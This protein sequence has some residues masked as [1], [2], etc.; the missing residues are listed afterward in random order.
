MAIRF[1][2]LRTAEVNIVKSFS[3]MYPADDWHLGDVD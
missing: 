1:I 2:D 3:S